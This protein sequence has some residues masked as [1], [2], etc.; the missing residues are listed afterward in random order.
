MNGWS[1]IIVRPLHL[2]KICMFLLV[3]HALITSETYRNWLNWVFALLSHNL[4]KS[5]KI[6]YLVNY[7]RSK[8]HR[9]YLNH[10]MHVF[11]VFNSQYTLQMLYHRIYAF[12]VNLRG[13]KKQNL[14]PRAA[15]T[16]VFPCRPKITIFIT[17][18]DWKSIFWYENQ[19]WSD[20]GS[21]NSSYLQCAL[22][23]PLGPFRYH[24]GLILGQNTA[25]IIRQKR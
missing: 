25:K 9:P 24:H 22:I 2:I 11:F 7:W 23:L 3:F 10:N 13:I 4:Y 1:L 15:K 17:N 8:V 5:T 14:G 19:F 6:H 16:I 21:I 12:W 20:K 18:V